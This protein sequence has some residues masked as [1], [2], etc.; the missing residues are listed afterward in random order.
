[1]NAPTSPERRWRDDLHLAHTIADQVDHLTVPRFEA[2]DFTVESKPD[3][4][5]V[6]EADKEAERVIRQHLARARTRDSVLG[7]EFGA[8][9]HAPRQWVVD[10]IDGTK[11]FVRGVPVWATLIALVEDGQVV[12]GVV[13]APA[14]GRRWWAV[15]E[16]G[17]WTG[18]SLFSARRLQVSLVSELE[19]ASLSYSSLS[20]WAATKRLRGMLGLMQDCWRT[21]AYGDFWSYTLLAEGAVDLAA[22]PELE[23]YDM[24][25]LVPIVTEAGG[26]FTSLAGQPGPWGSSAVASNTLLHA[27]ALRRLGEETD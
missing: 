26:R 18:R 25:A 5:P 14:L 10:P 27:E 21:R 15:Q 4:T 6:T 12:M 20:G 22:E 1:M 11:N 23:L 16:G 13:S 17:A 3:L 9:G 8:T 7:E 2:Q 24:A 19:E